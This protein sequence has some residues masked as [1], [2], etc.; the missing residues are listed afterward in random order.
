MLQVVNGIVQDKTGIQ[1]AR[2]WDFFRLFA[3]SGNLDNSAWALEVLN[4]T[5][6]RFRMK[7]LD[8]IGFK[9]ICTNELIIGRVN[10]DLLQSLIP[11]IE[12]LDIT[13][14]QSEDARPMLFGGDGR[15]YTDMFRGSR[16]TH[17]RGGSYYGARNVRGV[18]DRWGY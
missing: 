8:E 10:P 11:M 17:S 1:D 4:V 13:K 2:V 15:S 3:E 14:V 7:K 5:D 6:P 16:I 18:A 9:P 12:D